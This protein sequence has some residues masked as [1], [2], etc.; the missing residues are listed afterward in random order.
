M[1]AE[2][3]NDSQPLRFNIDLKWS[4]W[5]DSEPEFAERFPG[6]LETAKMAFSGEGSEVCILTA[7]RKECRYGKVQIHEGG[8]HVS[9]NFEWDEPRDQ[10]DRLH[11]YP[12]LL[13]LTEQELEKSTDEIAN[14]LSEVQW[15]WEEE[16][17]ARSFEDL[18][19]AIDDVE[20]RLLQYEDQVSLAFEHYLDTI[21]IELRAER[22]FK[23]SERADEKSL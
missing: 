17:T 8:A 23:A 3:E 6:V 10:A 19:V 5:Q 12:D 13:T 11:E 18:M 20:A 2:N 4:L 7:P 22:N 21:R 9:F 14:W 16:V 15:C 1:S